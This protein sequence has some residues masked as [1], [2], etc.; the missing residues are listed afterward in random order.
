[1]KLK[2]FPIL[3]ALAAVMATAFNFLRTVLIGP[4]LLAGR[5][6]DVAFTYRMGA[7]FP[8]DINRAHPV[9]VLAGLVNATNP[10]AAYGGPVFVASDGVSVRGVI[11]ADGSATP[12]AIYG[13]LVR[14][15]PL[16]QS[17]GGANASFGAA[18]PPVTGVVDVC[19]SGFIM[20]KVPAGQATV[21][22]GTVYA[23]AAATSG[24]NIQGQLVNAASTTNT[25]TITN[26]K[27]AGPADANGNV[28]IEV[29]PA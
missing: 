21:K 7:G 5:T 24:N 13:V 18:T 19:R 9:S 11:A 28:E 12:L 29:W 10:P 2:N 15:Y 22:G 17:S 6:T 3:A 23:W 16:Q 26:A 1:M 14:P 27:F 25:I 20:G 4:P 8:G